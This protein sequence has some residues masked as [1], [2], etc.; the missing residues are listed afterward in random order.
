MGKLLLLLV[1]ATILGATVL[2]LGTRVLSNET[3]LGHREGQADVLSR[4]IAESG[5]SV[6]LASIVGSNGFRDPG[7]A[8]RDYEGGTY[9][10][11][12]TPSVTGDSVEVTVTGSYGGAYHTMRST[13]E[14]DDMDY[15][16]P[17]WLD[18]PY[19]SATADGGASVSGVGPDGNALP[20]RFDRRK[21][22]QMGLSSLVP[23]GTMAT[24]SATA[25]AAAGTS[26][27]VPGMNATNPNDWPTLL[28][29]VNVSDGEGLYQAALAQPAETVVAGPRVVTGSATWG[30]PAEVTQVTGNLRVEGTL[31][32]SGAL[33]VEGGFEVPASGRV[34]WDGLI[35]VRAEQQFVPVVF[36]G[37]V[38]VDGA[39]AVV[40]HA[41]PPGGHLDVTTWR[42][43]GSGLGSGNVQGEPS[44]APWNTA[45]YPWY[46][47]KHRFD[48]DT[49]SKT[50]EYLRNGGAVPG[51]E[52]HTEFYDLIDE[53]GS[54]DVYFEV[55]NPSQH[56]YAR[57][58]VE[59]ADGTRHG[60]SVKN[61]FGAFAEGGA[62]HRSAAFPADELR[63]FSVDIRSLRTLKGRF[64]GQGGCD[65]WP[66][67]IGERWDRGG[68]LRIRVRE[69]GS[70]K[71]VYDSAL[72][73]HMQPTE[74]A[75]YNVQEDSWRTAIQNGSLFGTK[76]HFGSRTD[77]TYDVDPI[78]ALVERMGFDGNEL[79][80]HGTSTTHISASE[81][82]QDAEANGLPAGRA[83][84]CVGAR[85]LV[86]PTSQVAQ[87][88]AAGATLGACPAAAASP[89]P[90]AAGP[91][92]TPPPAGPAA[93][94]QAPGL[95][96]D[97]AAP[98]ATAPAGGAGMKAWVCHVAPGTGTR[99]SVHVNYNALPVHAGHAGDTMGQ[100]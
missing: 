18:V 50:V 68:T 56:G 53:L 81:A 32:G 12:Y 36:D 99:R 59:L 6:V 79:I 71:V 4:Q 35:V 7:F 87:Q 75:A 100:C 24:A 29:D 54:R 30:A 17:V 44:A 57:W 63:D 64:D 80:H 22:D 19:V 26:I 98:P 66:F 49:G 34:E 93:T 84:V 39:L 77:I 76:L 90:P 20:V 47:H 55:V 61:G 31:R 27:A 70:G 96:V 5:H 14:W 92:G 97:G 23:W 2:T 15:P 10:V 28:E 86:V 40:Q 65:Q 38:R 13:Y 42:D 11:V 89:A 51:I 67:C 1:S 73:W 83:M 9:A 85:E 60:G 48:I 62:T 43:T 91:G 33:I 21:Y 78:L 94:A 25:A 74:W 37:A 88:L 72:Y 58:R 82:R 3:T 45:A 16:S 95:P 8:E 69:D 46:Q 52:Q 41:Y